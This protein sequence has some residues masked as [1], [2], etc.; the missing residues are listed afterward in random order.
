VQDFGAYGRVCHHVQLAHGA[1]VRAVRAEVRDARVGTALQT[2][3]FHPLGDNDEDRA[4]AR[5]FDG[6][7]N[8]WYTDPILLGR[9]PQDTLELLAPLG[10]PIE[11]GDLARI[12]EPLDFVG[13]NNYTRTFVRAAPGPG[14]AAEPVTKHRVPGA[15]YTAMGWE[16][17][18][19]GLYEVL[20]R[21]R[22]EYG[23]PPLYVTENGGAFADVVEDGAIHDA[24]R[25]EL[26][27]EYIAS[28]AR[29]MQDGANVQGYFVWSLLDNF[30]WAHGYAKRFG[31]IHVDYE[32]G[33]RTSKDSA[34]WYRDMIARARAGVPEHRG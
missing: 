7:F 10:V 8:R 24:D 4:A 27:R 23:N 21:F 16:I 13:I 12:C 30:E 28:M 29:A 15:R 34:H 26:L 18:P 9:Y 20:M 6:L 25:C 11:D 31:L 1:A 22:T 14:L 17:Y 2:P 19:D 33:K 32:T 3:P 5:R